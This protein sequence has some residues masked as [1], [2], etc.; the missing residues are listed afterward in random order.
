[1]AIMVPERPREFTAA[2]QEGLMFDALMSL[3]DTY[4]VF[5]SFKMVDTSQGML[6]ES[7]TDFIIYNRGKGIICLEA[8]AGSGVI[9]S[10]G[11]WLYSS[12]KV[13]AHDGPF[14]QAANGMYR[15]RDK[16]RNSRLRQVVDRCKMLYGVWFPGISDARLQ[17]LAFP[18]DA[19]KRL[20]L[21]TEAL[22]DPAPYL[23]RIFAISTYFNRH[24]IE[25]TVVSATESDLLV[26][27]IFCPEFSVL[28]TASFNS[29]LNNIVF[30]R[31]LKEQANILNFLEDQ[32]IAVINGAAGT[33]KTMIAAEKARRHAMDG[34]RVLFLCYN[35]YLKDYLERN[36]GHAN[37]DF[38]TIAGL[39]CKLC[40]TAQP[41]YA[42]LQ[43][44]LEDIYVAG[45][46]PYLHIIIDEGQDFGLDNI[47]E[48]RVLETLK[49][50]VEDRGTFYVFYDR[51]QLVQARKMPAF[52]EDADCRL[53]LYKNCRNTEN[54]ATTSLRPISERKPKLFDNAVKGVPAGIHYCDNAQQMTDEL[55]GILEQYCAEGF[56]DV[57]IL[58][59][60]KEADSFLADKVQDG[61]YKKDYTFTTCR[62]FKGLEAEA[63]ILID[64]DRST[65][66]NR[67]VL[68]F[69]VGT[70]RART[71][72]EMITDM[73]DDDCRA[74]LRER[75]KQPGTGI[76]PKR[77]LA[78]ALNASALGPGRN[79]VQSR[80]GAL[81]K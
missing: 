42:G 61:K 51:L 70:S 81:L 80:Q 68:L 57:V 78:S 28:P 25:E 60:K 26:R 38:Q 15:L 72:L 4:Y 16:I 29:E 53:T 3:P 5:H 52:I 27:S 10:N 40:R 59:A 11:E 71:R 67:N 65:F 49:L 18:E 17:Q 43:K 9:Y 36:C 41:D 30:H 12:G 74:V 37:I 55:N 39:A 77:K 63:V 21:T 22:R 75:M 32:K 13:M 20:V 47:E 35:A 34:E 24:S 23:E 54:I 33:G 14:R 46:F 6:R 56:R 45:N 2:S 50:L 31:L 64:I 66:D 1:M 73:T 58:T 7:E 79:S 69:Y 76:S 48:G 8:K 62:K 19:D 44:K